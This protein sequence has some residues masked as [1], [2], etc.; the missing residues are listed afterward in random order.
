ME[1]SENYLQRTFFLVTQIIL[2]FVAVLVFCRVLE[3]TICS[4]HF[5]DTRNTGTSC[6]TN[7]SYLKEKKRGKIG[8]NL[9]Q[10]APFQTSIEMQKMWLGVLHVHCIVIHLICTES[11]NFQRVG[12]GK[13]KK[14]LRG[15]EG[16]EELI[17]LE[18]IVSLTQLKMKNRL[19]QG[20]LILA[21][22][23][24]SPGQK[25]S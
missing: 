4:D 5:L 1:G 18:S 10:Y 3:S 2:T 15:G 12:W 23:S 14:P 7:Q 21:L 19:P 6:H 20:Y 11:W 17:F 24:L 8:H 25:L 16:G 9:Y 22:L 13:K